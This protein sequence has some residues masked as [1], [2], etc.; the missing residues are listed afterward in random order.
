MNNTKRK[1]YRANKRHEKQVWK[2]EAIRE[3]D[4]DE[5]MDWSQNNRY[6]ISKSNSGDNQVLV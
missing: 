5:R 2:K 6:K 1:I 3:L 4:A